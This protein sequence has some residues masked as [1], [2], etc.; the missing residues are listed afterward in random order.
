VKTNSIACSACASRSKSL[1]SK[2]NAEELETLD[3]EKSCTLY[4]KGQVL[5]YEGTRPM[6]VFCVNSGKVKVYRT[7]YEGKEQIIDLN[8]GGS[9]LGYKALVSGE[10]Y[11]L[12]AETTEPSRICFIPRAQF[13]EMFQ[14]S[15]SFH[16]FLLE[17]LCKSYNHLAKILTVQSQYTVRER[18]ALTLAKLH[19]TY[20]SDPISQKNNPINLTR[21]DLANMVGTA[22]ES[23]IRILQEFKEDKLIQVNGRKIT[24]VEPEKLIKISHQELF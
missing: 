13:L 24:V 16:Q 10:R 15:E 3:V 21:E 2:L 8:G 18:T 4:K 12:S 22:T 19:N 17:E 6:G 11:E 14:K 7:G 9:I 23:L 5:F 1:F 20:G